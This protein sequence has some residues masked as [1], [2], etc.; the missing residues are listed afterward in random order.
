MGTPAVL[1]RK[2]TG[3]IIKHADYPRMDMQPIAGLDPDLEWLIK[4]TPYV[5]PDYDSRIYVLNQIESVT[6]EP[7]PE[8]AWLNQYQITY[9]TVKRTA[10]E[11]V[12]AIEN[13]ENEANSNVFPYQKQVKILALGVA[14]LFR[15]VE[16]MTLTAKEKKIK[17]KC[18]DIAVNIW[19]NHDA[20]TAKVAEV[21]AGTEPQIDAGWEKTEPA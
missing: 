5:E 19:K 14:T 18:L 16:N 21:T 2:S 12:Q 1:I 6:T 15:Q 20:A 4:T 17:K 13:A 3:E 10:D 8:W 7:H 11:I 9:Q